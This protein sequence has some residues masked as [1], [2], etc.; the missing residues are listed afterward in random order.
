M[1]FD[2]RNTDSRGRVEA[3]R[4]MRPRTRARRRAKRDFTCVVMV[5]V[6]LLLLAFLA[7]DSLGLVFDALAL[8]GLRL[9]IAADDGGR[10]ADALAVRADDGDRGRLTARVLDAIGERV[11]ALRAVAD[12]PVGLIALLAPAYHG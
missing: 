7:A 10:L 5:L 8:I 1:C 6:P 9:A 2:E 11:V 12:L 3:L 4:A